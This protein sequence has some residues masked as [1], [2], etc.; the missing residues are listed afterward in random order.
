ML[1]HFKNLNI[2]YLAMSS[3]HRSKEGVVWPFVLYTTFSLVKQKSRAMHACNLRSILR[4]HAYTVPL[5][6]RR[7]ECICFLFDTFYSTVVI[8]MKPAQCLGRGYSSIGDF[9][10]LWPYDWCVNSMQMRH[11]SLWSFYTKWIKSR[12]QKIAKKKKM[13]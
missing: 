12:R 13:K 1:R 3:V 4:V 2:M 5:I 10:V 8:K 11:L 6:W 9:H 7:K